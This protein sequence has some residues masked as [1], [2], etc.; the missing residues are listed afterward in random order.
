MPETVQ[1]GH[2]GMA[3][4]HWYNIMADLE[5]QGHLP[6][7]IIDPLTAGANNCSGVLGNNHFFITWIHNQCLLLSMNEYSQPLVDAFAA[8]VGY[9]PFC[10]YDTGDITTVEWDKNY[11][12]DRFLALSRQRYTNLTRL[13]SENPGSK[14]IRAH[15]KPFLV[16]ILIFAGLTAAFQLLFRDW[17]PTVILVGSILLHAISHWLVL[18]HYGFND[19][20]YIIPLVGPVTAERKD[21]SENL[22]DYKRIVYLAAGPLANFALMGLGLALLFMGNGHGK[23]ISYT[24]GIIAYISLLPLL[25]WGDGGKICRLVFKNLTVSDRLEF[26]DLLIG[27]LGI[28]VNLIAAYIKSRSIVI[29]G[30]DVLFWIMVW[31]N[32]RSEAKRLVSPAIPTFSFKKTLSI[33]IIYTLLLY[34]SVLIYLIVKS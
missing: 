12:E 4:W 22:D 6:N 23:E 30:L 24:N 3:R 31:F 27:I 10:R 25:G 26:S 33:L 1:I 28:L 5:I 13:E 34:T 15:I 16:S 21:P 19:P 20:V 17:T 8:V 11:P 2:G 9:Q 14:A 29:T 32:L 18:K 7:V